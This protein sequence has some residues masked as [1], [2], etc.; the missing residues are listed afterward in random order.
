MSN[1]AEKISNWLANI[2]YDKYLHFIAGLLITQ[3][4]AALLGSI[5]IGFI[6]A[7]VVGIIKEIMDKYLG[8]DCNV[9][10]FLATAIGAIV[11]TLLIVI[12]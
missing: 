1:I 2:G 4:G 9:Y 7:V 10:D 5:I 3:I 6:I 12:Q 8:G 11:G